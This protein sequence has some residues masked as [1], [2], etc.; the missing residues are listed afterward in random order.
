V[1]LYQQTMGKGIHF[2]GIA[3]DRP[4]NIHYTKEEIGS[5]GMQWPQLFS[6]LEPAHAKAIHYLFKIDSYPSYV[7]IDANKKILYR[8]GDYQKVTELMRLQL[9]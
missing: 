4:A 6:N 2:I 5:T 8:G 3:V 9:Q 7:L 1:A